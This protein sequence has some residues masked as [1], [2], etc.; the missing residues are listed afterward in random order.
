MSITETMESTKPSLRRMGPG[1]RRRAAVST[2][3][4]VR[5]GRLKED[6]PL[7][8]TIRPSIE[9]LELA[10]WAREH[11]GQLEDLL[12]EHRALL[13]RGFEVPEMTDFEA[14][15]AATSSSPPLEYKDRST[16]RYS[17]GTSSYISTIYPREQSIH[18]HN[19]S[20][21]SPNWARNIYFHCRIAADRGGQT[22]IADVRR[23]YQRLDPALRQPFEERG[24]LYVRNYN[25]GFGMTW[26]ESFQTEDRREVE[27]RCRQ[28]GMEFQWDGEALTTRRVRPAVRPHPES[29]EPLWFNHGAFFHVSS[30]EPQM[31]ETLLAE[32]GEAHL[33]NNTYY[34]DGEPVPDAVMETIQA[35]YEAEKV[36]FDWQVGDV[37]W[38]DNMTV[39]HGREP[40]EGERKIV[41]AMTEPC[42]D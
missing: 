14:F 32:L 23:V 35:A 42:S 10:S 33:P 34:G 36:L 29:G 8:F 11:R 22:P 17:V 13:F 20:S 26:Q 27:A 5:M 31:R 37:L 1:L 2:G 12:R 6:S 7:P 40:Y 9:G 30:L 4:M 25:R 19:E 16:P 15:V 21:Y 28:Q 24:I 38:L 39:A 41:V 18:M 3:E